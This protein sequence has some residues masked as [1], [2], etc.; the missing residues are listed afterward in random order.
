MMRDTIIR[1]AEHV[2]LTVGTYKNRGED[3]PF[4]HTDKFDILPDFEQMVVWL[5]TKIRKETLK[6][7][8][9]L[10]EADKVPNATTSYQKQYN[11]GIDRLIEKI[12][13]LE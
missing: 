6:A 4:V 8:V 1:Y 5:R 12:W 2:G 11:D 3:V 7:V 10:V 9:S 13:S